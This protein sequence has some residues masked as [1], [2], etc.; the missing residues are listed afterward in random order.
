LWLAISFII[1]LALGKL[2]VFLWIRIIS[3]K[4]SILA[5]PWQPTTPEPF[6]N[7]LYTWLAIF[8]FSG[9]GRGQG[10]GDHRKL[11]GEAASKGWD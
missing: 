9:A 2:Q 3:A 7:N 4:F 10:S 5:I 6:A 8:C 11:P 1:S